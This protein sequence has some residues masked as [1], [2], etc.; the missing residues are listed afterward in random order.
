MGKG[1]GISVWEK[2][3]G[4]RVKKDARG[5]GTWV[6]GGKQREGVKVGKRGKE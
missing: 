2:R 3:Q 4:L 1:E 5:K 6:K